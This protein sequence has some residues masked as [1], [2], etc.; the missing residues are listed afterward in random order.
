MDSRPYLPD[1]L[2]HHPV[3]KM[4]FLAGPRQVGKTTLAKAVLTKYPGVYLNYDIPAD[5]KKLKNERDLLSNQR[6]E[7]K[8]PTIIF[9]EIHKMTR[10]KNFLKGFF[11]ENQHSARIWVTGSGRLDLYQKGG[12]SLLGRYFLYHLHPFTISEL[13]QVRLESPERSWD[14]LKT[15]KSGPFNY[16]SLLKF[17]GF[18]EPYTKHDASF[19]RRWSETR[20]QRILRE[21]I[22]DLTRIQDIDR[23]ES[24]VELLPSKVGSLLSINSIREDL[25]VAFETAE[26]WLTVLERVYYIYFIKPYSKKITRGIRK[27][28]KIYFWDWATLTDPGIRFENFVVSHFKRAVDYWND[29]GLAKAELFFIRDKEKREVDLLL[30]VEGKPFCLIEIKLSDKDP[31]PNLIRFGKAI[32]CNQFLQVVNLPNT[33]QLVR[34]GG[35]EILI[36]S[37][38]I[39]FSAF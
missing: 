11:D 16:E 25:E 6:L 20:K 24:L 7:F 13:R 23:L 26:S 12:D 3:D 2:I 36:A 22:R 30:T 29:F 18:P 37:P 14:N 21:D 8:K 17:G 38:D 9:D 28:K 5:R 27:E 15:S 1:F 4:L 32:G 10:F 34:T 19:Y 39:V 33:K 35:Q 31:S